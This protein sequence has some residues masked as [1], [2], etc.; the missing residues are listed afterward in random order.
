MDHSILLYDPFNLELSI[1][2]MYIA[3][4]IRDNS[5]NKY[6]ERLD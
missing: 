6:V 5:I 4:N 1:Y 3:W 2:Y